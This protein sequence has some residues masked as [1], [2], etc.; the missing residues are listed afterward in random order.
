M[1]GLF[2]FTNYGNKLSSSELSQICNALA[3]ESEERGS[4]AT[5]IAYINKGRLLIEKAAKP[6]YKMNFRLPSTIAVMGHTR[7][8]TQ[9]SEKKNI[10]NHPF[11]GYSNT[12]KPFALAHNGIIDNDKTLRNKHKL[13]KTKIETDSYIAVQLIE[14]KGDLSFESLKNM[15]EQVQGSFSFSILDHMGNMCIVKGDSPISMLHFEELGLYIYASTNEILW[16]AMI[17]TVLFKHIQKNLDNKAQTV[18]KVTITSGEIIKID[19]KGD[20]T[21]S[22]FKYDELCSLS[23]SWWDFGNRPSKIIQ[24]D[25]EHVAELKSIAT[26]FGYDTDE[27]DAL[28]DSGY[29]FE[30]IE[31]LM[32]ECDYTED[33]CG[34]LSYHLCG[35]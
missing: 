23:Y 34:E 1:C 26:Q 35:K 14:Q 19:T 12:N 17:N 3:R 9:G 2:G 13:P 11:S 32:Y 29:S 6:A 10:N 20:I 8:S 27:V 25:D 21:K 28:L 16:K 24:Y 5:G 4:H 15:A 22:I 30:E 18:E 31:E 7:H 33:N